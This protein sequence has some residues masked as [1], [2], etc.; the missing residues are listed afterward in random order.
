MKFEPQD[1]DTFE[2]LVVWQRSRVLA[3]RVYQLLG[4]CRDFGFRNQMT[5]AA[6]SISN[7]IA[8]GSERL[9][10]AEFRQFLGYA[11]G[12]AGETRSQSYTAADLGYIAAEEAFALRRELKEISRMILGLIR[13]LDRS[14]DS[15]ST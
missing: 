8:E 6:N 13:S 5:N 15:T 7:N 3:V 14:D 1:D 9:G 11:K 10:K 4:E 12:S 2:K